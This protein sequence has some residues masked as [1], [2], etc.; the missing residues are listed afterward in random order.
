MKKNT[1]TLIL[2]TLFFFSSATQLF[3]AEQYQ[4]SFLLHLYYEN[5]NLRLDGEEFSELTI[6]PSTA[7][8]VSPARSYALYTASLYDK[9]NNLLISAR[10]DQRGSNS[11]IKNGVVTIV[12]PFDEKTDRAEISNENGKKM[13]SLSIWNLCNYNKTCEAS[14]G[15]T[16]VNCPSD[17]ELK[18]G[19]VSLSPTPSIKQAP[20]S[21]G[22]SFV[23]VVWVISGIVL[24]SGLA[25]IYIAK[26]RQNQ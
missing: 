13:I 22:N 17:C 2:L 12:T 21:S 5:G 24:V 25:M 9:N 18:P 10:V 1:I 6:E 11:E 26:K 20:S 16:K 8:F 4:G 3:A 14:L 19:A 15:E 7:N 23:I